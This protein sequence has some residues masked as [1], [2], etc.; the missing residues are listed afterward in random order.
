[1]QNFISLSSLNQVK[2]AILPCTRNNNVI[3][4]REFAPKPSK[5]DPY[6]SFHGD[7]CILCMVANDKPSSE[8][9]GE[10]KKKLF[11]RSPPSY[12]LGIK[13]WYSLKF[14]GA[15]VDNSNVKYQ[16]ISHNFYYNQTWQARQFT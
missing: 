10:V 6:R 14:S 12:S 15:R 5:S 11:K 2:T 4:R 8:V 1:M 3:N 16:V 7:S 9:V 13:I